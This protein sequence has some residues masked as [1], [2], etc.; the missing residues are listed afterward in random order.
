M[1]S[2]N[3][4]RVSCG[5]LARAQ[6]PSS[7]P[8][9][10]PVKAPIVKPTGSPIAT[11]PNLKPTGSPIAT[12]APNVKPVNNPTMKTRS[13]CFSGQSKVQ[14]KG[15][16]LIRMEDLKIGD[17]IM[18]GNGR[19]SKV[20]SFGHYSPN[21]NTDY[22]QIQI[23][24]MQETLEISAEH[25]LYCNGKLVPANQVQVGDFLAVIHNINFGQNSS[26]AHVTSIKA[27]QRR[28][29]YAPLTESGDIVVNGVVASNYI[30]R[31]WIYSKYTTL[32]GEMLHWIQNGAVLPYRIFCSM[33][34]NGCINETYDE[35]TG[36]SIWVG[37]GYIVE[38]WQLD[39]SPMWQNAFLWLIVAPIAMMAV[40][41]DKL[42]AASAS[43]NI[44]LIVAAFLGIM[45]VWQHRKSQ[46]VKN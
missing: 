44:Q 4:S 8:S 5:L 40:V 24:S 25:M 14:L 6:A 45:F 17:S 12:T 37:Y 19:F 43:S 15:H 21:V 2:D 32:S 1:H 28:G 41:A 29:A 38:Q 9:K 23:D 35:N 42:V 26:I 30:A 36:F 13:V 7:V 33:R 46:V 10:S 3:G 18:A 34:V 11:T 31:E 39:L 16:G 22:L 20:Y 27:I